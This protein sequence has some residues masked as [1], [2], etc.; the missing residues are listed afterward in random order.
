MKS[1]VYIAGSI[2]ARL[3]AYKAV[4]AEAERILERQGVIVLNPAMLPIGLRSHESYMNIC[5]P[6]LR[7]ADELVLLP[8]WQCSK[9]V[10]ME[11]E[12]ANRLGIQITELGLRPTEGALEWS[13]FEQIK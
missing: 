7:E 3:D 5:L 6:M 10:R 11:I 2:T 13:R 1:I 9:G 4:F 8:G 12:E